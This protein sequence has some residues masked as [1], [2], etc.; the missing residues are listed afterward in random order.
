MIIRG[1]TTV[2]FPHHNEPPPA[3]TPSRVTGAVKRIALNPIQ[4]ATILA[5]A[6]CRAGGCYLC[7]WIVEDIAANRALT[8]YGGLIEGAPRFPAWAKATH[9]WLERILPLRSNGHAG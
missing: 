5:A 3:A 4:R 2:T 7:R 6:K 9:L 8:G 1:T